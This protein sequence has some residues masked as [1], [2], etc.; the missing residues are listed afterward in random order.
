MQIRLHCNLSGA[1]ETRASTRHAASIVILLLLSSSLHLELCDL[2]KGVNVSARGSC[3]AKFSLNC[4]RLKLLPWKPICLCANENPSRAFLTYILK[5]LVLLG[6]ILSL[7]Q[8]K[9]YMFVF[10]IV[11]SWYYCVFVGWQSSRSIC[12]H[13]RNC[14]VSSPIWIGFRHKLL[15]PP[16]SDASLCLWT[17]TESICLS[18]AELPR[19]KTHLGG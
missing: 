6:R 11:H 16:V 15:T 13:Q 2:L 1:S 7:A 10:H 17:K 18:N 12:I 14:N 8:K 4:I 3:F 5:Q 9:K 19:F